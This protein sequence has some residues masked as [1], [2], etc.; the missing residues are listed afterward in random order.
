MSEVFDQIDHV[1]ETAHSGHVYILKWLE[2]TW[3]EAAREIILQFLIFYTIM[4]LGFIF[5]Y[6]TMKSTH[7]LRELRKSVVGVLKEQRQKKFDL[8]NYS[9]MPGG[10]YF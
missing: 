6:V 5:L 10:G 1:P 3:G 7:R 9:S 4:L 2:E 8:E